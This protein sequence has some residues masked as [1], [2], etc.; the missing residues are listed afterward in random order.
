MSVKAYGSY[1]GDEELTFS[2]AVS[3]RRTQLDLAEATGKLKWKNG[4][5]ALV[6][7]L[8]AGISSVLHGSSEVVG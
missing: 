3:R 4:S 2:S 5:V 7:S 8:V 6:T 1:C